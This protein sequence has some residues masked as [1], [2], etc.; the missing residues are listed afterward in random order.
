VCCLDPLG[1][2]PLLGTRPL[3]SV[4]CLSKWGEPLELALSLCRSAGDIGRPNIIPGWGS[5][6]QMLVSGILLGI[7]WSRL[8]QFLLGYRLGNCLRSRTV[9][10]LWSRLL[11]LGGCRDK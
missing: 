5:D 8:C 6:D 4:P 1:I 2:L 3:E 10:W 11:L 7:G 9:N